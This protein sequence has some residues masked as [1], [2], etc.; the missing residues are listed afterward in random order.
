MVKFRII[1]LVACFVGVS[2]VATSISYGQMVPAPPMA[3]ATVAPLTCSEIVENHEIKLEKRKMRQKRRKERKERISKLSVCDSSMVSVTPTDTPTPEPLSEKREAFCNELVGEK[4][5]ESPG[6]FKK[7][8][9]TIIAIAEQFR[10]IS[11]PAQF[12]KPDYQV[13][14]TCPAKLVKAPEEILNSFR[15]KPD[16]AYGTVKPKNIIFISGLTQAEADK[17]E[18]EGLEEKV[19]V[20]NEE[21]KTFRKTLGKLKIKYSAKKCREA[22]QRLTACDVARATMNICAKT[23]CL[24]STGTTPPSCSNFLPD[25]QNCKNNPIPTL[26]I[27]VADQEFERFSYCHFVEQEHES[28]LQEDVAR[29]EA[30]KEAD[31]TSK[32]CLKDKFYDSGEK[33]KLQETLDACQAD[34]M[35]NTKSCNEWA[36]T[37]NILPDEVREVF[38]M[39]GR[40]DGMNNLVT[41]KIIGDFALGV[42]K[43]EK[44]NLKLE[45]EV[46]PIFD[47]KELLDAISSRE[48]AN[49]YIFAHGTDGGGIV[50]S[51]GNEIPNTFFKELSPSIMSVTVFTCYNQEAI[52]HK[53][54]L[55]RNFLKG[56]SYTTNRYAIGLEESSLSGGSYKAPVISFRDHLKLVDEFL[57]TKIKTHYK[58]KNGQ[59]DSIKKGKGY[60]PLDLSQSTIKTSHQCELNIKGL[61]VMEGSVT[62]ELNRRVIGALNGDK[63][64]TS[65]DHK[66]TFDCSLLKDNADHCPNPMSTA[67]S[68][69]HNVLMIG[70]VKMD[71]FG[72]TIIDE[73]KKPLFTV[74]ITHPTKK[75]ESEAYHMLIRP[76]YREMDIPDSEESCKFTDDV[77]EHQ[78]ISTKVCMD[79]KP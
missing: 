75:T 71:L 70:P 14:I 57:Y 65:G 41:D 25:Y 32:L 18:S 63:G 3:S 64:G 74:E 50:D 31:A 27:C 21:I 24:T 79:W 22:A 19:K 7:L 77:Y 58:G 4:Q 47:I 68:D 55:K 10:L 46:K 23:Q 15:K 29:G 59:L 17:V 35:A 16:P 62:F 28:C 43:D 9:Y 53:Y 20:A 42:L 2:L 13:A 5:K 45:W 8:G 33:A 76:Y 37:K 66:I 78:W 48:V 61:R 67:N 56:K 34:G 6:F 39:M 52:T 36:R 40:A 26:D 11:N 38:E 30:C 49:V 73:S 44:D 1:S 72:E 69:I 12:A 51:Y 54:E 60:Y